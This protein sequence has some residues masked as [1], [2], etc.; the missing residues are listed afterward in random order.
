MHERSNGNMEC[1][2]SWRELERRLSL[3]D[4]ENL[5]EASIK[6]ESENYNILKRIIDVTLL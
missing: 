4:V 5:L 1:Y 6:V 2:L 3:Q